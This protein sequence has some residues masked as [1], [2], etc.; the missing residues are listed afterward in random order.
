M[1]VPDTRADVELR[2]PAEFAN[3][4]VVRG[5]AAVVA[6]GADLTVDEIADLRLAVDEVCSQV[7][8]LARPGAQLT[9]TFQRT[10]DGIRVRAAAPSKTG[11]LPSTDSFGWH[12]LKTLTDEATAWL[13]A[14]GTRETHVEVL[15]RRAR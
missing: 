2:L 4:P 10:P 13:G 7:I 11:R 3:L 6:M 8:A 9:C 15:K 5:V 12:V 1:T 14:D